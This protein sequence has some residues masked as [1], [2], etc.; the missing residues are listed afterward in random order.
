MADRLLE[1]V[2]EVKNFVK[3]VVVVNVQ[4]RRLAEVEVEVEVADEFLEK[5]HEWVV[6]VMDAQAHK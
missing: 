3:E 6:V 2:V 4:A 1:V 5:L